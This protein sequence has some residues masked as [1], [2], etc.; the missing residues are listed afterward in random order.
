MTAVGWENTIAFPGDYSKI[1]LD[2]TEAKYKRLLQIARVCAA[3][4]TNRKQACKKIE[5]PRRSSN[6]I[7]SVTHARQCLC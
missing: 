5:I 2:Y 7:S 3:N 6:F 1:I 4:V